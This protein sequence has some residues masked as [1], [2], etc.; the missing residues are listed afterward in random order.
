MNSDNEHEI[1]SITW[2]NRA[3]KPS[4]LLARLNVGNWQEVVGGNSSI[5]IF[6]H[7]EGLAN[8]ARPGSPELINRLFVPNPRRYTR[9]ERRGIA[10]RAIFAAYSAGRRRAGR[11][12]QRR[13]FFLARADDLDTCDCPGSHG[14]D[15]RAD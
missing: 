15:A 2:R 5:G 6:L 3:G 14:D 9:E 7:G 12:D 4:G 13:Y 1:V 11:R 10:A 8:E